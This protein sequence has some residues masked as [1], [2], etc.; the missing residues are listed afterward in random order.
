MVTTLFFVVQSSFRGPPYLL[1]RINNFTVTYFTSELSNAFF[2]QGLEAYKVLLKAQDKNLQE[3]VNRLWIQI[4]NQHYEFNH[5]EVLLNITERVTYAQF[6]DFYKAYVPGNSNN[7]G[8]TSVKE[9]LIGT[10]SARVAN[11]TFDVPRQV[12]EQDQ[13]ESVREFKKSAVYWDQ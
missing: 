13:Y 7:G 5:R 2:E 3:Q 9:L 12:E 8:Q 6:V 1:D 10:F 11:V 4:H